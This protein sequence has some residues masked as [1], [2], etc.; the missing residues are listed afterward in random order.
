MEAVLRRL[1]TVILF[2]ALRKPLAQLQIRVRIDK[3]L[4]RV[5]G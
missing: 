2:V 4:L 1:F 3:S 5:E